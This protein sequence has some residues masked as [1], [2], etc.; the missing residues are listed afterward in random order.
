MARTKKL[1]STYKLTSPVT[2]IIL[3]RNVSAGQRFD[4]GFEFYRIADLSSVWVV[5]NVFE[6]DARLLRDVSGATV[7]YLGRTFPAHMSAVLP[8]FDPSTRALKV[9]LEVAN[10]DYELRPDMFVDVDFKVNVHS[11]IMAP[12]GAVMDT[13]LRKAVFV[14]RGNGFFEPRKVETGA[15]LGDSVIITSGLTPGERIVVSGN[16]LIDSESRL[17][18]AAAPAGAKDPVC[19]MQ[20]D[21]SKPSRYQAAYNGTTYNFCS[22][23]C[24]T[25][26]VAN[27]AMYTMKQDQDGAR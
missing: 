27:P 15:R 19:G 10:A 9:R 22:E 14:D 26:F 13:G 11:A 12:V 4:K 20:L 21:L 2:G 6:N 8:E 17:Q 1:T 25:K 7:R 16:F 23:S 18:L 3:A 5:A 24:K